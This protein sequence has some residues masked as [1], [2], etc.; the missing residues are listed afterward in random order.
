MSP[1]GGEEVGP[2]NTEVSWNAPG[3]ELVEII[4]GNKEINNVCDVT[5]EG[6]V[7]SLAIPGI[8]DTGYGI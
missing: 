6:E 1:S 5:V 8:F 3:A 7:R 2:Q 4:I